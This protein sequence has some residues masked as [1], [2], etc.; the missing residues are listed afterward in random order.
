MAFAPPDGPPVNIDDI[1]NSRGVA[2][3]YQPILSERDNLLV[4][5]EI[6]LNY[7]QQNNDVQTGNLP[8]R[9][10]NWIA[11][12]NFYSGASSVVRELNSNSASFRSLF[13]NEIPGA[14]APG[15]TEFLQFLEITIQR[16]M[17]QT[18]IDLFNR[19]EIDSSSFNYC[20]QLI[21]QPRDRV[22]Q[23]LRQL[24]YHFYNDTGS[25]RNL[26]L[27]RWDG[28]IKKIIDHVVNLIKRT[29]SL[30]EERSDFLDLIPRLQNINPPGADRTHRWLWELNGQDRY[31]TLLFALTMI[32]LPSKNLSDNTGFITA[33]F[34]FPFYIEGEEMESDELTV[35]FTDGST[36]HLF[37]FVPEHNRVFG[38]WPQSVVVK[39]D[40]YAAAERLVLNYKA[41]LIRSIVMKVKIPE[42]ILQRGGSIAFDYLFFSPISNIYRLVRRRNPFNLSS[43]VDGLT[44]F[45]VSLTIY[46]NEN[47]TILHVPYVLEGSLTNGVIHDVEEFCNEYDRVIQ[48]TNSGSS[49]SARSIG[50]DEFY[51]YFSIIHDTSLPL[52]RLATSS[53]ESVATQRQRV[54]SAIPRQS[55]RVSVDG[56]LVGAPYAGTKKEKHYLS[57]SLINRFTNSPALFKTP[58]KRMNSCLMMSL[59]KAQMYQFVF[60]N[61]K[62]I[63]IKVTGTNC[64]MVKSDCMYVECVTNFDSMPRQMPFLEKINGKWFV[65]LFNPN[66]WRHD[67]NYI[68]GVKDAL[69][70][71]YWEM[72]AEEIWF[73]L[74][75]Q[76]ERNLDYTSLSEYGQAFADFFK[77]CISIYDVEVRCNRVHVITP[78]QKT[79]RQLVQ[80]YG[81]I[82]MIHLVYDQGHIHAISSFPSFVK[83]EGRKDDLR[84]YNYCPICDEKQKSDLRKN[85][86]TALCHISDCCQS[87]DFKIGYEEEL[88]KQLSTQVN[89]VYKA[90]KKVGNKM[91]TYYKCYQCGMEIQQHSYMDHFCYVPKK[92]CENLNEENLYVYDLECAQILDELGLYKHECNC[93]MIRK[94][95]PKNKEEEQGRYFP[96]EVEFVR[97]LISEEEFQNA[98]FIAFNG[99]SYDIHFLLRVFERGEITHTYVPSPTSKHKFIQIHL[100]EKN[101]R[102]IDFMRFIPGSLKNIAEAFEIPVSKG[103]FPHRFN[104]GENENYIGRIPA[105]TSDEDYW[106]LE[107]FR[108]QKDKDKFIEW[109]HEQEK[110][111]CTCQDV[112][113]CELKKWS[114][115]DEIKKYC[116]MDVIVLA[117]IVRLYRQACL[118]FETS[119]EVKIMNWS[120][121]RLDPL[122]FMT[123]PQITM[124]T[125]VHGFSSFDNPNYDFKGITTTY[126]KVRGGQSYEGILWVYHQMCLRGEFI[127]YLGNSC[128]EYYDFEANISLDG[129]APES[130]SVFMFLK[131]DYW[132]CPDCMREYHEFNWVLPE[133]SM[134]ISDVRR[135]FESV[136]ETLR[137]N[138]KEVITIWGHEFNTSFVNPYVLKCCQ[139]MR[140]EDCFYGGRTE[141]FQLYA[142]AN[143]LDKEIHYYDVTSLYPSVYAHHPLP[144]GHPVHL[145]GFDVDKSRFH[146]TASNRYYGYARVKVRPCKSDMI[147]LLPQRDPKSGRLFFPVYPMEG[148]WGTEELYLAMQNGYEVEEIYELY[149]WD[150]RNYSNLHFAAYV[151]Y[152]FQLKQEA[153]GWKKLGATSENPSIEEQNELVERLYVQNGNLAR[154]RPEKVR[155]NAVLRSLAKLYLNSLWG[156]FAQKSAKTQ[157]TTVYGTQQFLALWNNKKVDQSN[158]KFR[159]ISPGVYKTSYNLKSEYVNPVRHGNLFIAAKV[160]ETARCVLHRKMLQVGP[161]NIIYCDTDSIIFLYDAVM[162]I[163]TDV[164]LGKWTNE[165]PSNVI[166]HVYA[167]APKLYSLKLS[168][169][170]KSY[171]TF[172][173][174]GIQMTLEN[175]SR[176]LFECVKPLIEN[177]VTGKDTHFTIPVKNFNIFSNSGNSALPYGQVFSRYNEKKVRAIITKRLFRVQ[178]SLNWEECSQIRTF[179][180]GYEIND[181]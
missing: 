82:L 51:F 37:Y 134:Y 164:G 122:Q 20:Q 170:D 57:G 80:D 124:Q 135:H 108:S 159:E 33:N 73:H 94:V 89:E 78:F 97:A 167:L 3:V 38:I 114:F 117:E 41:N 54:V 60:Q 133:R 165:Y 112:C 90:Y 23:T 76:F 99:G 68:A 18:S 43:E 150:E 128:K 157:H 115:Q 56:M 110:I 46:A 149:Y 148:C 105:L 156:K 155:K 92:K 27:I 87:N 118:N 17:Y 24:F 66:K 74:Q 121:P 146:P 14:L 139:V 144:V 42:N 16:W 77:V 141:V 31:L 55:N 181:N 48:N 125:L 147:G 123:L 15:A 84:L 145:L 129:Y 160:T 166:D 177:L 104:N 111:Y 86:Q 173:A 119:S 175:Q 40:A 91:V 172:R 62:C 140:P 151:N 26:S 103:D 19:N 116:L 127:Y 171:E 67:N 138:Y 142:N 83:S 29:F 168:Q 59:I 10:L 52:S 71:E 132:G 70:E 8:D 174:K 100:N 163:L 93:L 36:N 64:D 6:S 30:E 113:T 13:L 106:G 9:S 81:N 5:A 28:D 1:D 143:K 21:C 85:K 169:K 176:M 180:F 25:L 11:S 32:R 130:H 88:D 136:M 58:V 102:F 158:C 49:V 65:K 53:A 178:E 153:E 126:K 7:Q 45:Y 22:N 95:C 79:P 98:L 152:F 4:N 131:C 96:S 47:E 101:I 35:S 161:E 44:R 39:G 137:S 107:S 2:F 69:E 162:G 12:R 109:Y 120:V 179:P 63:D 34:S 50:I 72:A 154:I 75:V 61:Q